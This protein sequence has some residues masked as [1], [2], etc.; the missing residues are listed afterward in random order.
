MLGRLVP[1][2]S[3]S[4]STCHVCVVSWRDTFKARWHCHLHSLPRTMACLALENVHG[5]HLLRAPSD[6]Q[7]PLSSL[8]HPGRCNGPNYR[9][10]RR[11]SPTRPTGGACARVRVHWVAP[12]AAHSAARVLPGALFAMFLLVVTCIYVVE[13][14]PGSVVPVCSDVPVACGPG[15]VRGPAW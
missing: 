10:P 11:H 12:G 7:T 8:P 15:D 5:A 2:S 14:R 9:R 3:T 6:G 1:A 13:M 4:S